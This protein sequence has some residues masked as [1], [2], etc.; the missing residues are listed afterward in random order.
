MS[1]VLNRWGYSYISLKCL[2][3]CLFCWYVLYVFKPKRWRLDFTENRIEAKLVIVN[4]SSSSNI[5][6]SCRGKLR[7]TTLA[8][9]EEENMRYPLEISAGD[10]LHDVF[11]TSVKSTRGQ[12][13]NK[14]YK[15]WLCWHLIIDTQFG[16]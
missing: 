15:I 2:K 5:L 10:W 9:A 8:A 12:Q 13:Q 11:P 16:N 1:N 6:S 7:N 3:A 14:K 4:T